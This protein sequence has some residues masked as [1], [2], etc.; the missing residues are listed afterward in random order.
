MKAGGAV[1]CARYIV[2][3][4]AWLAWLCVA[5]CGQDVRVG[6]MC[7]S[8]YTGE[9]T[10]DPGPDGSTTSVLYGTSCAPCDSAARVRVDRDGC[11][12]YVTLESCGGDVCLFGAPIARSRDDDAGADDA[13]AEDASAR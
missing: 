6:A 1:R 11:P 10:V 4:A 9:A 3:G 12:I 7:P 13:G 2:R 8:P 5:A